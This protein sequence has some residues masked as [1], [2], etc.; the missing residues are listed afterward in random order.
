MLHNLKRATRPEGCICGRD[1][2]L[3][4]LSFSETYIFTDDILI[5][6]YLGAFFFF[7]CY[8]LFGFV[9]EAFQTWP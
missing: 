6:F 7:E 8:V 5:C 3:S 1:A 4:K 9:R 2:I